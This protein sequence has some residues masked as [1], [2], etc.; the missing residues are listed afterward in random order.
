MAKF[1]EAHKDVFQDQVVLELGAGCGFTGIYIS[2]IVK[3]AILTDIPNIVP[4]ISSNIEK[5][6]CSSNVQAVE[7]FW[8]NKM[9]L[10]NVMTIAK[11]KIDYV[12]GCDVVFDF[13]NFDGLVD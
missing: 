9:H 10:D 6:N 12:V 2:S 3:E 8:G 4:L 1:I 11:N 13:E 5:N 7:L